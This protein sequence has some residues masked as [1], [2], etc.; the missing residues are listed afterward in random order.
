MTARYLCTFPSD[1]QA[2]G[3]EDFE[4]VS[5]ENVNLEHRDLLNSELNGKM[6]N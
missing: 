3:V 5:N 6:L 4:P 1:R 2:L